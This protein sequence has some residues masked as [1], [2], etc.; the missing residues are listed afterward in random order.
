M[1]F[2]NII[3]DTS[4]Y[5]MESQIIDKKKEHHEIGYLWYSYTCHKTYGHFMLYKNTRGDIVKGNYITYNET[6]DNEIYNDLVCIDKIILNQFIRIE[7]N[8]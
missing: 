5:I 1:I 6:L 4:Y 2:Y 8:E 3:R 7:E